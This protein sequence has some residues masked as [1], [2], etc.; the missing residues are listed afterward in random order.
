ME[1]SIRPISPAD[2]TVIPSSEFVTDSSRGKKRKFVGKKKMA[3]TVGRWEVG[4]HENV[5]AW[6]FRSMR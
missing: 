5:K 2:S 1:G 3:D 6:R 4:R